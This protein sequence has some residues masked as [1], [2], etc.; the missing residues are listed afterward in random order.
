MPHSHFLNFLNIKNKSNDE[1]EILSQLGDH[2]RSELRLRLTQNKTCM[3]KN[4]TC[5]E[6]NNTCSVCSCKLNTY[7]L[8]K[9]SK[10]LV[11]SCYY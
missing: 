11:D 6:K 7:S 1:L 8:S 5:M 3:E 4:N 10:C 9:C 2:A